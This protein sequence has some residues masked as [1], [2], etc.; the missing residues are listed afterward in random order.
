M[1]TRDKSM[2]WLHDMRNFAYHFYG[3]DVYKLSRHEGVATSSFVPTVTMKAILA[4]VLIAALGS[5]VSF[6]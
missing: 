2:S 3:C 4:L 1:L 5:M 6:G